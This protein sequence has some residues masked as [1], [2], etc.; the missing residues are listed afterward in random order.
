VTK[1]AKD[2]SV[3]VSQEYPRIVNYQIKPA[4]TNTCVNGSDID[5]TGKQFYNLQDAA[6]QITFQLLGKAG[7]TF[8]SA[9]TTK[10]TPPD[11]ATLTPDGGPAGY[12]RI[13]V[14]VG[15]GAAPSDDQPLSQAACPAQAAA[16]AVAPPA[17]SQPAA[18]PAAPPAAAQ[19]AQTKKPLKKVKQP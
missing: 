5:V 13:R 10:I 6:E 12:T 4:I 7:G 3:A 18:P 19:P 11:S 1:T 14:F 2:A 15:S 17:P 16:P 8:V 9:G